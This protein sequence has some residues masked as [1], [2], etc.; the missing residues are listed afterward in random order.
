MVKTKEF[1]DAPVYTTSNGC[2]VM[3]PQAAQRVGDNGPLLLQDFHLIDLLAHFDRE[4][5]PERY[6]TFTRSL[7]PMAVPRASGPIESP[8]Y[9]LRTH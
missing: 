7:P 9:A 1:T 8:C 3:N 5:I 2:P 6:V 4:R